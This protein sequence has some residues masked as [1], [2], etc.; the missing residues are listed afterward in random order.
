MA[1]SRSLETL[2]KRMPLLERL[3][4]GREC[5]WETKPGTEIKLA[6]QIREALYVASL[7]RQY[8]PELAEAYDRFEIKRPRRTEGVVVALLKD[9][10]EVTIVSELPR[11]AEVIPVSVSRPIVGLQTAESIREAWIV[12]Q[13]TKELH[14]SD[15]Q[16]TK[17][18]L[19]K[20]FNWTSNSQLLF[21]L[22]PAG[23]V[24]LTAFDPELVLLS[25]DPSD[26]E[27]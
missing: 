7:N 23:G 13:P 14:F 1:Y 15:A 8:Y 20:L 9:K 25:W 10:S 3:K 21:F 12:R 2:I 4:E 22:S 11:A 24:R 17:D 27:D 16:L 26:L 6:Q 5:S 19:L 18:E